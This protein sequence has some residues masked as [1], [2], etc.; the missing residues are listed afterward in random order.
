MS[1]EA[2]LVGTM[3]LGRLLGVSHTA[4]AKAAKSGRISVARF[5]DSGRPLFDP[6][7]CKAEWEK[8]TQAI[9]QRGDSSKG[10]RPAAHAAASDSS[11]QPGG[12]G[13]FYPAASSQIAAREESKF[14]TTGFDAEEHRINANSGVAP[15]VVVST[16]GQP[17]G[18]ALKRTRKP[19]EPA[20]EL[21]DG[22]LI[23]ENGIPNLNRATATEKYYKALKAKLDYEE[24]V[25]KLVSIE[26][27][28]KIVEQEYSRVRARLLAIPSKLAPDVALIDDV[29]LCR[30][31][32]E[33]MITDA[34]SE[35][36]ADHE[37]AEQV[38][39]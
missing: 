19:D 23:D 37:A 35:L 26:S 11:P 1:E 20:G 7:R 6:D 17:H 29:S 21:D 12:D 2:K 34:L 14:Q 33:A 38:A 28:S 27:V 24:A 3:D 10:G 5:S 4:V 18:G 32:I 30:S 39:A 31:Q 22:S 8:N 9:M 15:G 13:L 25:G 36:S 16:E